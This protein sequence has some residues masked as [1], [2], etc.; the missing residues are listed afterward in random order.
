MGDIDEGS[1]PGV[2]GFPLQLFRS[3]A[4]G[5]NP[6]VTSFRGF[7]LLFGNGFVQGDMEK[8]FGLG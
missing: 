6:Y 1:V 5:V 8:G 2:V 7:C 4:S 3:G